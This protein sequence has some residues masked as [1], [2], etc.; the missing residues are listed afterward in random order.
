MDQVGCNAQRGRNNM[1]KKEFIVVG[2]GR[3]GTSMA[4][5]LAQNNCEVLVLDKDE[6][7]VRA[8][9]DLVTHPVTGDVTDPEVLK[10]LGIRNFDGAIVA[11]ATDLEASIMATMLLKE[12]GIKHVLAKAQSEVHAKVLRKVGADMVVFPEKEMGIRYANDLIHGNFFDAVELSPDYS[13][14]EI[15]V[16]R[17]WEGKSLKDLNLRAKYKINVIG[18]KKE[19]GFDV[20]PDAEEP[21]KQNDVLITIGRNEVLSKLAGGAL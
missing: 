6:E 19:D 8:M 21:L 20:S 1:D 2:L 13:M 9:A 7:K 10:G 14:M 16:K 17:G 12:L 4:K 11:I 5:T 15:N 18:I 3:F